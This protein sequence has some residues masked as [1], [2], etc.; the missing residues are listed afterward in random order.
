MMM[1][2]GYDIDAGGM[3]VLPNTITSFHPFF[4]LSFFHA[5]LLACLPLACCVI[6]NREVP[7]DGVLCNTRRGGRMIVFALALHIK[8]LANGYGFLE[9]VSQTRTGVAGVRQT[10]ESCRQPGLG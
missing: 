6:L 7:V 2:G 9:K 3:R 5:C 10:R 1:S 4:M 8:G